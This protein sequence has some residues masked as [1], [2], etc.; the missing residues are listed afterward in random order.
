MTKHFKQVRFGKRLREAASDPRFFEQVHVVFGGT[1]AV[2]GAMAMGVLDFYREALRH[3]KQEAAPHLVLTGH[4]HREIRDFTQSLF[5]IHERDYGCKPERIPEVGY[6]MASGAVIEL[7]TLSIDPSIPEM[8]NAA[9]K[10]AEEVEAAAKAFQE[11]RGVK[12]DASIE[13]RVQV[14]AEALQAQSA[15]PFTSFLQDFR[16]RRGLPREGRRFQSVVVSIPLASVATYQLG[17]LESFAAAMGIPEGKLLSDLKE[18]YLRVFPEDLGH[19]S[20][21]L[22]EEVLVAHTTGIG[23][24]YDED[25]EGV[26]TIRLGFAHS[27]SQE[28]LRTKQVFAEKLTDLYAERGIRMLVTAAAIGIDAILHKKSPPVQS[29]ARG[30]LAKAMRA[31]HEVIPQADYDGGTIHVYPPEHVEISNPSHRELAFSAGAPLVCDYVIKSGENGYFSV[32]NADA[33]YRVMR[34]ASASELGFTLARTAVFGDDPQ[35]PRFVDNVCYYTETDNSRQV[36]DL[37]QQQPLRLNQTTGLQA[38]ALQDLGSPKHQAELHL[39]G[40]L[41]LLHRLRTLDFSSIEQHVDLEYFDP[42]GYFEAHSRPL[43]LDRVADWDPL[44]LA[45]QLKI[46]VTARDE[47]DLEGLRSIDFPHHQRREAAWRILRAVLRAVWAIPSLG[48]PIL[49]QEEDKTMIAAGYF[50]APIDRVWA[51][52]YGL[53]SYL[54][55]EYRKAETALGRGRGISSDEDFQRFC[56][57]HFANGFVDLRPQATLVTALSHQEDLRGKVHVHPDEDSLRQALNELEPYSYFTSSGLV[58]LLL[59][60]KGLA[61]WARQLNYELGTANGFRV[62]FVYDETGRAL[63]VPGVVEA[64]RMVSEGLEKNTGT[65]MLDGYW[66]YE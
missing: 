36:F 26:R 50:L 47:H 12:P 60:L 55:E 49:Y 13:E 40:L 32:P 7:E 29:A 2:G 34:V 58:A 48:S 41:I 51:H 4:T 52:D 35:A 15:H 39:L 10:R 66:G 11:R 5:G 61:R 27:G 19:I 16:G 42:N 21:Q 43:T 38:K 37:L 31:G 57:F 44:K 3:G 62:H 9:R 30:K 6:R 1:G 59:R 64:F 65:E 8:K 22:A 33:L 54:R 25:P 18:V 20:R 45:Q 14:L 28:M 46:L 23:G 24:M 53:I 17:D 63:L 56:E